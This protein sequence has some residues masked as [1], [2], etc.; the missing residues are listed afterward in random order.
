M[1]AIDVECINAVYLIICS[2]LRTVTNSDIIE[3]FIPPLDSFNLFK[4]RF[5]M[6]STCPA[7]EKITTF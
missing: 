3:Y 6:K 7:H 1:K 4:V 5:F 2:I